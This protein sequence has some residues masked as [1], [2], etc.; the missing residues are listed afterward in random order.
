MTQDNYLFYLLLKIISYIFADNMRNNRI[1]W[2]DWAKCIAITMVVF[3]HIPQAEGSFLPYYICT[4]HIPLF[5][6][7]SGY[8]TKVRLDPKEELKKCTKS[9][10]IPYILYNIIFYP[11]WAIR[12]YIDQGISFS[13]ID[14][15]IKPL[16][17]LPFLQINSPISSSV[18]GAM[19]F[20]AVLLIMRLTVLL[21]NHSSKPLL[22]L[23]LIIVLYVGLFVFV[24]YQRMS[25]PLTIEGLLKCMPLYILG[26]FTKHYKWFEENSIQKDFRRSFILILISIGTSFI[27]RSLDC[28]TFHITTFYVFNLSAI[29]GILYLCKTL[30]NINSP[31]LVNISIGT[32]MIMGLHWMFIGTT[33]YVLEHIFSINTGITYSWAVAIFFAICI[34]AAIYPLILIA[35]KRFPIL[36]GK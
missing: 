35:K 21:C 32:L 26:Y 4:F 29:F 3:G 11:Y 18:N 13:V 27:H 30:N 8:L 2:I 24:N 28:F 5:F 17:G 25:L 20:L 1:N 16:M 23:K 14:Y 7:I 33:N 22:Y 9:L 12:L 36:L 10:V 19:W 15:V 34:D 31:K 6:F